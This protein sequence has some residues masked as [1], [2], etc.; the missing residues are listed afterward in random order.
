MTHAIKIPVRVFP[1]AY[2]DPNTGKRADDTIVLTKAELNAAQIVGQSSK[3]LINRLYNRRGALVVDIGK[4]A[5]VEIE[6][7]L[8]DKSGCVQIEGSAMLS[9][10][11]GVRV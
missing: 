6:V 10:G 8:S 5:K 1:V 9:G 3:E 11:A 2:L 4:A 7:E